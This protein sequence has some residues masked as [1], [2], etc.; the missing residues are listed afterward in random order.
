MKTKNTKKTVKKTVKKT[1]PQ[2][3][4]GVDYFVH[5]GKKFMFKGKENDVRTLRAALHKAL[6]CI[7]YL[8]SG[9]PQQI[10]AV[11]QSMDKELLNEEFGLAALA[12]FDEEG[13]ESY[14]RDCATCFYIDDIQ[15]HFNY[16]GEN[17]W[18]LCF[19]P[20]CG[21]NSEG[22]RY[23]KELVMKPEAYQAYLKEKKKET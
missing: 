10:V 2:P 11:A 3:V 22:A 20:D 23:R 5:N 7:N 18:E 17:L 4:H 12:I 8:V 21:C 1:K 6:D 16:T 19:D 15:Q 9:T 13:L 14:A